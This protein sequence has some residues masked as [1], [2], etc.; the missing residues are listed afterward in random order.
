MSLVSRGIGNIDFQPFAVVCRAAG[1]N[2]S[3]LESDGN[4]LKV[5]HTLKDYQKLVLYGEK[6][7]KCD[8]LNSTGVDSSDSFP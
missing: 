6:E 8:T 2:R 5:C 1:D 4:W 3:L 7:N